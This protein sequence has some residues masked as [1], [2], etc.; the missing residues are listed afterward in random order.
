[1]FYKILRVTEILFGLSYNNGGDAPI[2]IYI[3]LI[4]IYPRAIIFV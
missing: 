2:Y 1:M 4:L 3:L